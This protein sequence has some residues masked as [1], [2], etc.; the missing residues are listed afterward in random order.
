VR[1]YRCELACTRCTIC[2]EWGRGG[3]VIIELLTRERER[4]K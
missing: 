1:S 3:H 4:Y 2:V